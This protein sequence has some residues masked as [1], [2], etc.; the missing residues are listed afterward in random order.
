MLQESEKLVTADITAPFSI[1]EYVGKDTND[2]DTKLEAGCESKSSNCV[3]GVAEA[4]HLHLDRENDPLI[5]R[6]TQIVEFLLDQCM[7]LHFEHLH[8][9][10]NSKMGLLTWRARFE[11]RRAEANSALMEKGEF[12]FDEGNPD[13]QENPDKGEEIKGSEDLVQE[14]GTDKALKQEPKMAA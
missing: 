5:E 14:K 6:S 10:F 4:T 3:L 1:P 13:L 8:D 11:N 2:F 9:C 12:V 7:E